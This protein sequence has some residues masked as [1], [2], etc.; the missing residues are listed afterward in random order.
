MNST[1]YKEYYSKIK[2]VAGVKIIV[3]RRFKEIIGN[4][5]LFSL[6]KAKVG[7]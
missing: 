1:Y 3:L 7:K 4:M 5:F 2:Y 6:L